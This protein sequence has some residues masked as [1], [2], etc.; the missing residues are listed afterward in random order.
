MGEMQQNDEN[1]NIIWSQ[2]YATF[3][4]LKKKKKKITKNKI[5]YNFYQINL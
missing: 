2:K 1:V 5:N 3:A 4:T